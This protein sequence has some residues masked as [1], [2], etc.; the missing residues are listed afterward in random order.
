[1]SFPTS[2]L[3][4]VGYLVFGLAAS[5][6]T[7]AQVV[8][9]G[10]YA[11]A[12]TMVTDL[13]VTGVSAPGATVAFGTPNL[14]SVVSASLNS[15]LAG[16]LPV[17]GYPL[18]DPAQAC[19]APGPCPAE[20]SFFHLALPRDEFARAD[21]RAIGGLSTT[22]SDIAEVS[23]IHPGTATAAAGVSFS[24]PFTITGPGASVGFTFGAAPYIEVQGTGSATMSFS[25]AIAPTVGAPV[26]SWL[27]DGVPGLQL[28]GIEFS[29]PASL[30]Q[31]LSAGSF[32]PG[33][34]SYSAQTALLGPG[35][36]ML[37][38]AMP[39]MV[40]ALLVP[41]PSALALMGLGLA[42]GLAL[43]RSR[44]RAGS[45]RSV[46]AGSATRGRPA[47]IA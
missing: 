17:S 29:D 9:S 5:S 22:A 18:V 15:G 47:V 23:L 44:S 6:A 35:T 39:E 43:A 33:F 19:V 10:S 13:R 1:M 27:P 16:G 34:G 38:M 37:T 36:Y 42:A 28:G 4:I 46:R 31:S 8:V 25:I 45:V 30:N 2:G 20:N 41:E 3:A 26:F 14:T 12:A 7:D 11:V 40:S 24:M 32:N 21:A